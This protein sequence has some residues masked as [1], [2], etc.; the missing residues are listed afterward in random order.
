M[1]KVSSLMTV[2]S[3]RMMHITHKLDGV[4]LCTF[5]V[6]Y[7]FLF[8]LPL[9]NIKQRVN[10]ILDSKVLQVGVVKSEC[11]VI[12]TRIAVLVL[13]LK[14]VIFVKAQTLIRKL[15]IIL[16]NEESSAKYDICKPSS[17]QSH[18]RNLL[19]YPFVA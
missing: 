9:V 13:M 14:A 3:N 1:N 7:S 19:C 5:R 11:S 6:S 15:A 8:S 2:I 4:K 17:L 12:L 16:L 18:L 10:Y